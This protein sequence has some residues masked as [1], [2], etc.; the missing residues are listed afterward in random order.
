MRR[1]E[2]TSALIVGN[3]FIGIELSLLLADLG[4]DVTVVGRRNWV[5][6][7]VLDPVTSTVAEAALSAPGRDAAAGSAGRRLRRE[8]VGHRRAAGRRR[9][10][11]RPI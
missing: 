10:A 9:G 1:G 8:P 6:P 4:V 2:A 11:R 5:M 3:G 7:R